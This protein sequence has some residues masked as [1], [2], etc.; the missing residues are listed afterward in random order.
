[1]RPLRSLALMGVCLLL[2]YAPRATSQA[3]VSPKQQAAA[4]RL[5]DAALA[6]TSGYARLAGL[7]DKFG[8]RLSGS[9]S[10]EHAIDWILAEMRRDGFENVRG[11]PVMV[12][13]W[14]RGPPIG[15]ADIAASTRP[16]HA[17]TRWECRDAGWRDHGSGARRRQL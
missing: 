17:R 1:M 15:D 14:V 6:D 4:A 9:A 12:P 5:I 11:E 16:P 7:T 3:T 13:H 8:H 2:G 10:L